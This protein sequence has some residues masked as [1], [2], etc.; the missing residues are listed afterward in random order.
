MSP[1][2]TLDPDVSRRLLDAAERLFYARGVQAVGIDAVVAEA[3]VATK[4]LYTHFGSKDGLVEAYL[5]R[6]DQRWLDWLR[7]AVAAVEPGPARVSAVFDALGE[8]FAEPG[9]N[10]CAFINVAGELAPSPAAR[11]AARDHKLALRA[12]LAEVAAEA[13][14]SDP[15]VLAERLMLL[16]E[17]AIVTAHVE[18]DARA[19]RRARSAAEALLDLDRSA[20][21][22]APPPA[23]GAATATG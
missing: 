4:T 1:T 20:G 3:G 6:R 16:V 22:T 18:G 17:G 13:G 14:V 2:R 15:P 9:Y 19:A 23:G 7:G 21:A 5:R 8:W 12:L 11:A 10:G